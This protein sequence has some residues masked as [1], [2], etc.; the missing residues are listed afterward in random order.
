MP[1]PAA[2]ACAHAPVGVG[3]CRW[4]A[5]RYDRAAGAKEATS[6]FAEACMIRTTARHTHPAAVAHA[7]VGL[8]VYACG[9][10]AGVRALAGQHTAGQRHGVQAIPE[11][12]E[13]LWPVWHPQRQQLPDGR[14]RH[15]RSG[16]RHHK[17]GLE[18]IEVASSCR[19]Q[20]LCMDTCSFAYGATPLAP[21]VSLRS[22][23]GRPP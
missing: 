21:P 1:F 13:G 12:A 17:D 23:R 15:V 7:C 6:K 3:V 19:M 4:R 14:I 5:R 9:R 11:D 20:E 10:R 16:R 8:C 2:V 22:E 18:S